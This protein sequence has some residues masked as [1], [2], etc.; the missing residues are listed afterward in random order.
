MGKEKQQMKTTD[1]GW[2]TSF[3]DQSQEQGFTA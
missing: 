3:L 2:M 1:D